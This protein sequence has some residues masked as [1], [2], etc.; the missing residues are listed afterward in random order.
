MI[1]LFR[2]IKPMLLLAMLVSVFVLGGCSNIAVLDPKGPVAAQQKDL[3]LL[4]IGFMLFI[5]GAVFVLFTIILVKYRERKD[6]GNASYNPE[7]HGN[8]LLEV[9][10][11]V[12]PIL[13]V[14]ALS[15]PTVKTIY[16]LEEAPQATSHKDPLV[17]Y[18]TAVDWKWIFS[19]PEENIE[20]VNYLNIPK[21]QPILFK[22]TSADTMASLWIPQLGGEKYAM[23]GME[24]E[25]YL[26]ADEVGTYEGR[27][28]NFTGEGF[29]QQKFKVNAMMQ[30]DYDK[31]VNKTKKEAPK[32]TKKTY[33]I[34]MLP[35]A[36]DVQTFSSTHLSFA[37]HGEDSE[38]ALQARKRLGYQ[39]VSPHSKTDPFENVKNYKRKLDSE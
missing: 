4:S 20:T 32:L 9:V 19:Y 11:T 5:V 33:D 16:S 35:D 30:S 7:I 26:Q 15:V 38:Y 25:Q 8:T 28:A 22:I 34:L 1:F 24:M 3:I 23:A 12:I 21:D 36:A 6:V 27:N 29:A 31:W 17:I 14:A 13:I 10:W 2:A 18:A 37:K 39:S